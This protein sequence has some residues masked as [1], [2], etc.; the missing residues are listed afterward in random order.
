MASALVAPQCSTAS[1]EQSCHKWQKE[2]QNQ[3]G[4]SAQA[5]KISM[6]NDSR[7]KYWHP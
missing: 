3:T 1:G 5:V 2:M 6:A 4:C 7:K